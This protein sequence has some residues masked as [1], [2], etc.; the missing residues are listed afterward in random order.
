MSLGR[1]LWSV[2]LALSLGAASAAGMEKSE[3]LVNQH[4]LKTTIA[5]GDYYLEQ[6][7]I[8]AARDFLHRL[9]QSQQLGPGWNPANPFWQQAEAAIV[10]RLM[11]EINRDFS[12]LEWL[13]EEWSRMNAAEFGEQDLD[14]LLAHF[15]TEVGRKQVMIV[16]HSIAF[17][18][19]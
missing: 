18:V 19:I 1:W 6:E 8:L 10:R 13:S 7:S 14:L 5:I 12:N 9:G 2:M 17:H 4:D 15:D 16:D 11:R 3:R